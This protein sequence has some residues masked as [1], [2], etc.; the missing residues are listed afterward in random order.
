MMLQP[1]LSAWPVKPEGWYG[2]IPWGVTQLPGIR[3]VTS[4]NFHHERG[5]ICSHCVDTDYGYGFAFPT[6]NTSVKTTLHGLTE[7]LSAI[8]VFQTVLLLAKELISQQ[9]KC[10]N[11]TM[12]MKFADLSI[13]FFYLEAADLI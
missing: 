12:L 2:T 8:T 6:H 13:F 1:S 5:C 10:S 3:L 11:G 4:D 7:C 9:I